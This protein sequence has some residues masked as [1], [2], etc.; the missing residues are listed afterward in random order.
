MSDRY[1]VE[2]I[3]EIIAYVI[4]V[5]SKGTPLTKVDMGELHRLGYTDSE[6]SAALSW[7]LEKAQDSSG[8]NERG[9]QGQGN[10]GSF[11]IL[12]GIE[13]ETI[14]PE[15]W[16]LLLSYVNLGFLT[17]DDVE[18]IIERAMMMANETIV[19]VPEVRTLVAVYVMHRGPLPLSGSRSLLSGTDSIN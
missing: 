9:T 15:G 4:G 1:T 3:M 12:H 13:A 2:R 16:G 5:G 17:N 18:Q 10:I 7:I 6:I 19:D 11:R 14:T 8:K